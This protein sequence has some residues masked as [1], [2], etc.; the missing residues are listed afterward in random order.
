[1]TE[2]FQAYFKKLE[3]L[4]TEQL[5]RSAEK[6][7]RAEK[8]NVALVIAHIAEISRRKDALDPTYKNV[9][10]YYERR[11]RLS[12]GSVA[13]R[14]QVANVARRFPQILV[15]LADNRMSL[16][17]AGRLAPIVREENVEE[18]LCE[19][20]GKT[21]RE[22]KEVL[23]KYKEQPVFASSIRKLPGGAEES[24]G[25]QSREAQENSQRAEEG[26]VTS[27]VAA[28][29]RSKPPEGPR[30]LL[31]P[32]RPELY[33]FRFAGEKKLKE[34]FERLAEVL[35]VE[36]PL[37][38]MAAI[39]EEAL[40]IAL[41]KKDPKRKRQRRLERARKRNESERK[42]R[43]D[44]ISAARPSAMAGATEAAERDSREEGATQGAEEPARS[45]YIPSEVCARV[46]ERAGY[47]CEYRAVDGKRC[48]S[49]TGLQ[50][51]HERPF[52]IYR[53]HDERYLRAFC[54][55][56]NRVAAER[57]YGAEFMQRKIEATKAQRVSQGVFHQTV[58]TT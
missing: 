7:V 37:K 56:H 40:D 34:K 9:F 29:R 2:R 14:L 38:K 42:S 55:R 32:A 35:G 12:E 33:N 10:D 16:S 45:R 58:P 21:T 57:I 8:H 50:I 54:R 18:L 20:A 24:E 26:P 28:E 17:V 36:H 23:V 51:E 41:D 49:R 48:T 46:F 19:C 43:A 47:Q 3:A 11:L 52:A 4:S 6:L 31:E 1:M 13:M 27:T 30:D 44:E 53:S 25:A 39:F 5:D 15:A 22:V